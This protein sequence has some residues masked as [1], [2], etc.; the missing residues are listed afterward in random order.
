MHLQWIEEEHVAR[1]RHFAPSARLQCNSS[2][3]EDNNRE[4]DMHVQIELARGTMRSENISRRE[5]EPAR[6]DY[7][8]GTKL[9]FI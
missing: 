9:L 3:N 8:H 5:C 2:R 6:F 4:R 7:G 1:L